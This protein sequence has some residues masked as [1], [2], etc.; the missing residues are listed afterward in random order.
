MPAL[1][2]DELEGAFKPTSIVDESLGAFKPTLFVDESKG[3][4]KPTLFVGVDVSSGVDDAISS[5]K[6]CCD[7]LVTT[8]DVEGKSF[9]GGIF[10]K[11]QIEGTEC[12][13][14]RVDGE[15]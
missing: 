15:K 11:P 14:Q 4:F 7:D 12:H 2:F 8:R 9:F 10:H 3:A 5:A 13:C 1:L 6:F